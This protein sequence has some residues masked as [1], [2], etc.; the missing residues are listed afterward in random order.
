MVLIWEGL[1]YALHEVLLGHGILASNDDLK[2]PGE[3][4]LLV[5]VKSNTV[6]V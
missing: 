6:K 1:D 3:Y 4:D 5:N 2:N